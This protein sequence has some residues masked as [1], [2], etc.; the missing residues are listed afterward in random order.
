MPVNVKEGVM[1][2]ISTWEVELELL[3]DF[4]VINV[5]T[6]E[7]I[8]KNVGCKYVDIFKALNSYGCSTI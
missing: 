8:N 7:I 4:R 5:I 6:Y 3:Q 1:P 2:H